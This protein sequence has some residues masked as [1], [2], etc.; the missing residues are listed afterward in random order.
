VIIVNS[1]GSQPPTP[2]ATGTGE[3][4]ESLQFHADGVRTASL[5]FGPGART[6][7]HTHEHGQLLQVVAGSGVVCTR[8]GERRAITAGDTVWAPPDE[9]HW[10][11]AG[12]DSFLVHTAVSLGAAVAS[13]EVTADEY[14][15]PGADR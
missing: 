10:H 3:L 7:W 8:S 11:G 9:E 12:P 1:A 5:F 4:W 13:V 2:Q 14:D 6:L 15:G